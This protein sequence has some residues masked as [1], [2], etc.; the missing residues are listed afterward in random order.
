M[1]VGLLGNKIFGMMGKKVKLAKHTSN[2]NINV[3]H[4]K[5]FQALSAFPGFVSLSCHQWP[6]KCFHRL[7]SQQ[8]TNKMYK[9]KT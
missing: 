2:D 5:G 9:K 1:T 4:S 7:T 8:M 6:L 3:T